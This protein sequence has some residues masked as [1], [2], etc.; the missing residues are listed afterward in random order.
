M[1]LRPATAGDLAEIERLLVA[2]DLPTLGVREAIGGFVIAVEGDVLVGAVAIEPCGPRYGLLRSAVVA[3]SSR[4]KGIGRRLVE[5]VIGD[6]RARRIEVLYLLTT[7]AEDY[8][9][10][11]GFVRVERK[12]VPEPVRRTTEFSEACPDTAT[13]MILPLG[14]RST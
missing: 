8:F 1:P 6:A 13:V 11:F 14:A 2:N 12:D 5:H 9:P 7:T 3:E 4:G 10:S